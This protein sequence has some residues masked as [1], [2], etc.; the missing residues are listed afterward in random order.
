ME[1]RNTLVGQL[2]IFRWKIVHIMANVSGLA[3]AEGEILLLVILWYIVVLSL[4]LFIHRKI[5]KKQKKIHENIVL[6]YDTIRYQVSK[7]QY[8][9]PATQQNKWINLILQSEHKNYLYHTKEIH[10][11]IITI[12]QQIGQQLVTEAQR[13]TINKQVKKKKWTYT[14]MQTIGRGITVITA[15]IY[16]L[17][18]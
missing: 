4:L 18:W 13:K 15:G 6:L 10:D 14:M 1:T 5:I 9:N 16:K 2:N 11:E 12:E 7:A 17:F 8:G 3:E